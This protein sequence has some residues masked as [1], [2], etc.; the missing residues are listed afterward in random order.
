M[1]VSQL[2]EPALPA[3]ARTVIVGGGIAGCALAYHLAL[4]GERDILLLEQGR[5]TCGTTWHAAG[6]VGQMRPNRALTLMSRYGTEL[7]AR[8]EADT[9]LASGW[10]RC[11]SINVAASA[12]RWRLMQRQKALAASYGVRV[13]AL[14]PSEVAA[15]LPLL[16][17]D[18]LHGALWFPD[19]GKV[20]PADLC[21]SLAKGARLRGVRIV[22]GVEVVAV[23]CGWHGQRRYVTGLR[24]AGG[25]QI[26]CE[27]LVNCAGIWARQFG[28]LAGVTVPL[29]AA[30]HFY[31]V[32]DRID[33]VAPDLPVLRDPDGLIYYKEEVGGLVM[34]GFELQA[35]PW[36]VQPVPADF[37]FRLLGEDWDQF[38]P[39]LRAAL[40][41]TPCLETARIKLLLNGPESF[42]PDGQ[43]IVGPAPGLDGYWVAAGFNSSG[44]ANAGGVGRLLA[45]WML[46]GEPGIDAGDIDIARFPQVLGNRRALRARTA[47][48][49]GLHY[50]LR[51]PRQELQ[52]ARP[53][54]CSPLYELLAARGACFGSKFGWERALVFRPPGVDALPP[55]SLDRPGW[56]PWVRD[57][58]HAARERVAVIDQTS[59]GKLDV[60]G[61]GA[62]ALLQRLCAADVDVPVGRIVYTPML[63][64]KGGYV[65]DLT[66]LR[67]AP[68]RFR[69]VTG[70][71]QPLRDRDWIERHAGG[72]A[73]VVVTDVSSAW[74]VLGVYG[75]QAPTL[76]A[77]LADGAPLPAPRR[78]AELDL[79][80]ARALVLGISYPG[81]PG[82]ELHLPMETLRHVYLALQQEGADLGLADIGYW[83][84]D[85]L[86]IEAARRA[87]GAELGAEITPWQAGLAA[88]FAFDKPGGFVGREALLAARGQP[89]ARRLVRLRFDDPRDWAWGGE[90]LVDASS[91]Q[92]QGELSSA[93]WSTRAG[94]CVALGWLRGA[95]AAAPPPAAGLAVL[96]DCWGVLRPA[97]AWAP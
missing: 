20:N 75:P 63:D 13:E 23:D 66:L 19:D 54:R 74:G 77:R 43:F 88:G 82:C 7:Y 22:E 86:R 42:T 4:A 56:L 72:E 47:E 41:R 26:A 70:S 64:D 67:L 59:F 30:E 15:R 71:A 10:K 53:L 9:G 50:A 48:T 92:P 12:E 76:L 1:S 35:K 40:H 85:G 51:Y 14:T 97:R 25:A 46:H 33:G 16:R 84:L 31:L 79:G 6:L 62:L 73:A 11:G 18:D 91:G 93:G 81:G 52:S 21:M 2:D 3:A 57:E 37:Q 80:W 32:T 65:S 44:I 58:Q 49:L 5:L 96:V 55:A 8:L 38:E 17:C 95:A 94:C 69:I 34:G 36:D 39:L 29:H 45:D 28:A 87:M 83:A 60:A 78:F 24:T 27:R 90:P 68:E 61:P 89:L